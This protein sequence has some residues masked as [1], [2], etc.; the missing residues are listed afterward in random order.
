MVDPPVDVEPPV[1]VE[2]PVGV[3]PPVVVDPPVEVEPPV[4]VVPPVVVDPP[5]NNEM[6]LCM[7]QATFTS[8][9]KQCG[10]EE[11][12]Q[13]IKIYTVHQKDHDSW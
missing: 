13:H 11:A 7:D 12:K 10:R 4:G 1:V 3:E 9:L 2:P 8:L 5:N 6:Y